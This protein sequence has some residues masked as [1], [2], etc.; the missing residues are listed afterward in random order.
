MIMSLCSVIRKL[1]HVPI[2]LPCSVTC[3]YMYVFLMFS[4]TYVGCSGQSEWELLS[5][6]PFSKLGSEERVSFKKIL[7]KVQE[8]Q[9][10]RVQQAR[11]AAVKMQ[12]KSEALEH[13]MTAGSIVATCRSSANTWSYL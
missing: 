11:E 4:S 7:K 6:T 10:A 5:V 13:H 9:D 3:M 12:V 2:V 8:R 1:S